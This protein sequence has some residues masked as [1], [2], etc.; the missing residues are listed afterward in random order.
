MDSNLIY[1]EFLRPMQE[2][3]ERKY[4]FQRRI[5][6]LESALKAMPQAWEAYCE[7]E[8]VATDELI[9]GTISAFKMG[10]A[11]ALTSGG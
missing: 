1:N 4:G 5:I 7:I 6:A 3:M 2:D 9:H 11:Y 10:M 8:Q